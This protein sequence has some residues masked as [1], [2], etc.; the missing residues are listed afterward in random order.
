MWDRLP[1]CRDFLTPNLNFASLASHR[2]FGFEAIFAVQ[3][4]DWRTVLQLGGFYG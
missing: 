2:L 1:A 4:A 3:I